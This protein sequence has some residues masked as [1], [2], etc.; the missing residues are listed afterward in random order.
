[1][2]YLWVQ[3]FK[4]MQYCIPLFSNKIRIWTPVW[5]KGNPKVVDKNNV[6]VGLNLYFN[7]IEASESLLDRQI[8]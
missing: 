3:D 2:L 7:S 6:R 5:P 4:I 8:V 1:M